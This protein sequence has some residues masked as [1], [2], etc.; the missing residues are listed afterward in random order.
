M[1]RLPTLITVIFETR[2]KPCGIAVRADSENYSLKGCF[3]VNMIRPSSQLHLAIMLDSETTLRFS[4]RGKPKTPNRRVTA[5]SFSQESTRRTAT[6]G[7]LEQ[8]P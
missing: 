5:T 7:L 8:R 1:G 2:P 6:A 3:Q 4:E